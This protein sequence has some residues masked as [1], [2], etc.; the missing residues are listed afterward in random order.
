V[1]LPIS[2]PNLVINDA[3]VQTLQR[4]FQDL[5]R[6]LQEIA[7]ANNFPDQGATGS[8]PKAQL[9]IG[10]TYF[11]TTLGKPVWWRGSVWVDATGTPA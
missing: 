2:F 6:S 5:T 9:T 4:V 3:N 11:D 7:G 10:Q 8:R 1:K